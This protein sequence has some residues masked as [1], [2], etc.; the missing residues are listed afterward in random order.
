MTITMKN[1]YS[2]FFNDDPWV[3]LNNLC[4][5][6]GRRLYLND[7]RFWVS[8]DVDGRIMLFVHEAGDVNLKALE[9]LASLNIRIDH[10]FVGATRLCC[11]LVDE[12]DDLQNKFSIV[13]KDIAY[14]C[15]KFSGNELLSK[16]QLRIKSWANFLKPARTGLSNSEYVG[17]WGELY[18]FS[19]YLLKLHSAKDA[20]RFWLGP[21][22]KKQDITLNT[23]AI[24]IKTSMTGDSRSIK[25]S[26]IDQLEKVTPS[27]FLLH[28]IG[29]PSV[30]GHGFSLLDLYGSC[31]ELVQHDM[32]AETLFLNKVSQ[33]Y[34]KANNEQLNS[35]ISIISETMFTITDEFPTL[36][37]QKVPV[38]ISNINYEILLSELNEFESEESI[39]EVIKNG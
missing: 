21:E 18:V 15:S 31:L 39:E 19:Q 38:A 3:A 23:S 24:E 37:R 17:F 26:S 2:Q 16:V 36:T 33:L 29:S 28:L 1:K 10:S 27:L 35:S 30:N 4:Y 13:A 8:A 9:N 25:I 6:E 11:T 20:V 14:N 12:D 32:E 22:G 34:G 7:E 5:P